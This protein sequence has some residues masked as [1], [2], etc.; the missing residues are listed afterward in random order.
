M[1]SV[2]IRNDYH[3]VKLSDEEIADLVGEIDDLTAWLREQQVRDLDFI[4]QTLIDGLTQVRFRLERIG[5]LGIGYVLA[6]LKEVI[7]AYMA[8]ERGTVDVNAEPVSAAILQKTSGLLTKIYEKIQTVKSVSESA[9]FLLKAYVA[10]DLIFKG[11]QTISGLL[12][13]SS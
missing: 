7:G 10:A 4:R 11:N 3:L 6:S 8:L 1:L 13:G 2:T 12:G 5:W 9:D